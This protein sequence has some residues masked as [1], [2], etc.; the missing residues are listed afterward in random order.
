MALF[1][2]SMD[3]SHHDDPP[4][5]SLSGRRRRKEPRYFWQYNAQSKGPKGTKLYI[6]SHDEDPHVLHAFED[7]VFDPDQTSSGNIRH[8]GKARRGDGNDIL[9]SP[10][11]LY[12]IGEELKKLN[13]VIDHLTP[14]GDAPVNVKNKSKREKNKL[15][16]R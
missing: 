13:R 8:S 15:A 4:P 10:V 1:S 6:P 14:A 3:S 5:A 11:K 9:P 7:P 12:Q 2:E 16:S